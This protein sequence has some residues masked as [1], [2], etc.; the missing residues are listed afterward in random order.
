MY[1]ACGT[2]SEFI[3]C[4]DGKL[5]AKLPC[6]PDRFWDDNKKF[7]EVTSPTCP[8]DRVDG[9]YQSCETCEGYVTCSNGFLFQRPCGAPG[10]VW[11]D[12]LKRCEYTSPTCDISPGQKAAKQPKKA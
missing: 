6:P 5:S 8:V 9:D 4:T 7:C 12:G 3:I 10:L 11:D 2:C 1:H